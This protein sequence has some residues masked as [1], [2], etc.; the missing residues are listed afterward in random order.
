MR[1]RGAMLNDTTPSW[2]NLDT[3]ILR[4]WEKHEAEPVRAIDLLDLA[5]ELDLKGDTERSL[6]TSLSRRL[7]HAL[8]QVFDVEDGI[9]VKLIESGRDK[10]G[11]AK[12]GLRYRLIRV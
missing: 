10:K 11:R 7:G 8:G 12:Q 2:E 6:A 5:E 1:N 3:L 9:L 4:W